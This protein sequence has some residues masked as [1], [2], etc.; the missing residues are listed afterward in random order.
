[1]EQMTLNYERF[2]VGIRGKTK[3]NTHHMTVYPHI[4]IDTGTK[5]YNYQE[6][7][8]AYPQLSVVSEETLKLKV[9]KM[10]LGQNCYHRPE[11]YKN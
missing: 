5:I 10:I 1:M 6:L 7:K 2:T 9:V 8:H 3:S 4:N 11:E